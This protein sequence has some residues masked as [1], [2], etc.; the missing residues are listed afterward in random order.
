ME[1]K[2]HF[3]VVCLCMSILVPTFYLL[4]GRKTFLGEGIYGSPHFS[5]G[6]AFSQIRETPGRLL[7]VS[8]DSQLPSTQNNL[9]VKMP[10]LGVAYSDPFH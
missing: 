9:Y 3:S 1:D 2:G 7:S 5:E 6:S 10:Y 4:R 8:L